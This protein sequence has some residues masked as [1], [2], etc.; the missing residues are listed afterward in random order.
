MAEP[1]ILMPEM[2]GDPDG[3]SHI[4]EEDGED[5]KMHGRIET[6]VV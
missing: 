6:A 3:D 1:G 4:C 5:K 2:D